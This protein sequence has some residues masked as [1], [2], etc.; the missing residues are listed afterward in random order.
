GATARA[1]LLAAVDRRRSGPHE[2]QGQVGA[3]ERQ[4]ELGAVWQEEALPRMDDEDRDE[5]VDGEQERGPAR[6][7][8]EHERDPAEE[9]H[10]RD[11]DGRRHRRGD[12]EAAEQSGD[13]P[14]VRSDSDGAPRWTEASAL[15][16][17]RA[18]GARDRLVNG[19]GATP[20]D[21]RGGRPR[22]G[23]H[24]S[25]RAREHPRDSPPPRRRSLDLF[26]LPRS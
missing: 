14:G 10:E 21:G 25:R 3:E 12:S 7:E 11:D 4:R 26:R 17:A 1:T 22:P 6:E 2:Q 20:G 9:L 23:G 24:G 15:G 19:Y 5:H 8:A 18:R 13:S 16:R